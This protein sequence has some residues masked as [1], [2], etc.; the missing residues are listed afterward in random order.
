MISQTT[1]RQRNW[2][3]YCHFVWQNRLSRLDEAYTIYCYC[4]RYVMLCYVTLDTVTFTQPISKPHSELNTAD[5]ETVR[6]SFLRVGLSKV[7]DFCF[8]LRKSLF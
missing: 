8:N 4:Y 3:K 1:M 7:C 6:L 5:I 2:S